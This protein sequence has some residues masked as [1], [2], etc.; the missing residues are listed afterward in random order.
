MVT[1]Q[2]VPEVQGVWF[3]IHDYGGYVEE[4]R[5]KGVEPPPAH[6][7]I[8]ISQE[9]LNDMANYHV[10]LEKQ[11]ALFFRVGPESGI[12]YVVIEG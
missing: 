5:T 3:R 10:D 4:L 8:F 2:K 9:T 1:I 6:Y 12:D 7:Q 11:I